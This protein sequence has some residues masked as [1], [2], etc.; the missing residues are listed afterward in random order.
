MGS[1]PA[2]CD[3]DV[4]REIGAKCY[5]GRG[6][7]QKP[8]RDI[9]GLWSEESSGAQ[10]VCAA[11]FK[12]CCIVLDNAELGPGSSS[13]VGMEREIEREREEGGAR[14]HVLRLV[15]HALVEVL[16]VSLVEAAKCFIMNWEGE[17]CG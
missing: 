7:A 5:R 8:A 10:N 6:V 13:E 16:H 3:R 4:F 14:G 1:S 11:R 17:V 2:A 15:P 9:V 12:I